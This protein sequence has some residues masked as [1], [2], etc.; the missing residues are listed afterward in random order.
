MLEI[1]AGDFKNCGSGGRSPGATLAERS[2]AEP[3]QILADAVGRRHDVPHPH[4][5]AFLEHADRP[6]IVRRDE[7][8]KWARAIVAQELR[9]RRG[10]DAASPVLAADPVSDQAPLVLRPA[11]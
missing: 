3:I 11:A 4:E 9:E 1:P 10:R 6:E 8:V 7:R 5:A 2:L